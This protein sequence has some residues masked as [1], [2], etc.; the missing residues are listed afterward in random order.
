LGIAHKEPED[1]SLK[2]MEALLANLPESAA[3]R[4]KFSPFLVDSTGVLIA[5]LIDVQIQIAAGKKKVPKEKTMV[6]R[7]TR[8]A[9][10]QSLEEQKEAAAG[11]IAIFRQKQKA[12]REQKAREAAQKAAQG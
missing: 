8:G 12:R 2:S 7:I 9:P 1:L 10:R 3:T 5:N 11:G 4:R 6:A